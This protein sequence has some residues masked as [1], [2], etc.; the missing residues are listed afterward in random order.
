MKIKIKTRK[1]KIKT[2]KIKIKTRKIKGSQLI[3]KT[4]QKGG[5]IKNILVL[6][7]RKE[8]PDT[9]KSIKFIEKY[10]KDFFS[11]DDIFNIEY[12]TKIDKG[13]EGGADYNFYLGD[14]KRKTNTFMKNNK[15]K[16]HLIILFTCPFLTFTE[17]EDKTN[18]LTELLQE[19]GFVLLLTTI[20][21]K[22]PIPNVEFNA[23][24]GYFQLFSEDDY[25]YLFIKS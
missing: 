20:K 3:S 4:Q 2:R 12:L 17:D 21:I 18:L 24:N 8:G 23:F 9:I 13:E 14:D 11:P 5:E 1:I 22:K 10:V 15:N 25:S 6:C 19:P 16:Y 7:Q